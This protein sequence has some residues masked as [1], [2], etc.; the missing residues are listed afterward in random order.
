MKSYF[1][2]NY[3]IKTQ[4]V[5]ISCYK[6]IKKSYFYNDKFKINLQNIE[7]SKIK[8]SGFSNYSICSI[9]KSS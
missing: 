5:I 9:L 8:L 7:I 4:I 1:L 6:F 2:D 3:A